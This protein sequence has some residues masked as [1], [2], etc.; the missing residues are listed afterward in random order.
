[1]TGFRRDVRNADQ[2][3]R[4]S[5]LCLLVLAGLAIP[6]RVLRAEEL[7][8]APLIPPTAAWTFL[9]GSW[10][11]SHGS[12]EQTD[13][14]GQPQAVYRGA[15]VA[16][17]TLQVR[18]RVN[19][20][21]NGVQAAGLI[22]NA[23]DSARGYFIHFDTRF[24][25]VIL[26]RGDIMADGNE[27]TRKNQIAMDPD[28]WYTARVQVRA[29]RIEVYLD[30]KLLL[31]AN[32]RTYAE[33]LVGLYT[34]Q[35]SVEFSDLKVT[36]ERAAATSQWNIKSARMSVATDQE[37]ATILEPQRVLCRQGYIGWPS[38]ALAPNGDLIAAF[39]GDRTGH[40]S[41]DGKTQI[42]RSSNS[43]K[44]WS[45]AITIQDLRIDDR[46]AG[47]ICTA[48]GTMLVSWFTGPPYGTDRQGH[49]VIRS[50]DNGKTWGQPIRTPVTTPHGP[51]QLSDGRLL[52]MGQRPHSSHTTP[53]D[54][55]GTPDGSPHKVSI[56]ESRDDGLTWK[57]IA[58]FPVPAGDR[59]LSY[60][61]VH[62]VETSPGRLVALFRDCNPPDQLRQSESADGGATWSVPHTTPMQGHP[63]HVIRLRNGWLLAVYARRRPPFGQYACISRDL[64]GTWDVKK[65]IKLA[66][67]FEGDMGYPASVQIKDG[68][69]W[70]VYYQAERPGEP[71]ALMGTHWTLK[72]VPATSR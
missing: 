30:H 72:D 37:L 23:Q 3:R 63:P 15:S 54:Y 38:I 53:K 20:A 49:Y 13:D 68:S 69:I 18:F 31:T 57:I 22:L 27:I 66:A 52:F 11:I 16:D 9:G 24:D 12:L 32:D 8:D 40:I 60:D 65:E 55:N 28:R 10:T 61:E 25:Q 71:P 58:D 64:G 46:D 17:P 48:K 34:S 6:P 62:A 2:S 5:G 45:P 36:G 44:T 42:S 14:S 29:G 4:W 70:T 41:E 19:R 51:I 50:T 33:G 39:S 43:G 7:S 56:S 26:F 67:A 59:M 21:G 35:G 1:M 47:I